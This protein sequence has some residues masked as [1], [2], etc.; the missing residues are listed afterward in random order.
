MQSR[1]KA[2]D[3]PS[4]EA[5]NAGDKPRN[6]ATNAGDKPRNEATKAGDKP[7]NEATNLLL[8]ISLCPLLGKLQTLSAPLHRSQN[9]DFGK[10]NFTQICFIT[11]HLPMNLTFLSFEWMWIWSFLRTWNLKSLTNMSNKVGA[12]SSRHWW[13][14]QAS[15]A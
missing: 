2:G 13:R 1:E 4:N 9:T 11:M 14:V 12:I 3:K 7:R 8:C 6:E 15:L 10:P 5:T